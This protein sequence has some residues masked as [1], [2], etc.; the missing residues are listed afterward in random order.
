MY[1][2][3]ENQN[4]QI[5]NFQQRPTFSS[6]LPGIAGVDGIPMWVFYVNRGQGIASFGVQDKDH[7][8]MEFLPADKSY[9]LVQVQGFRTFIKILED[10]EMTFLEPFSS[11]HKSDVMETMEIS[12]NKL[13]L[14]YINQENGIK[15]TVEYFILPESPVAGLVR[16][17][18]FKNISNKERQFELLDGLP[19]VFPSGVPNAAYKELGNTIKS[20]FDVYNLENNIPFYKLRGSMEDTAEVKEVHQGN[21]F[22]SLVSYRGEEKLAEPIVDRDIIFGTDTTLQLPQN[23]ISQ[24]ID[25]LVAEEAYTTNKVS[26]GF[27]ATNVTLAANEELELYTVVGHASNLATVNSY[28]KEHITLPRLRAMQETATTI[29]DQITAPIKCETG[30]PLFDAYSRQS[31]LDNGLRGGFPFVFEKEDKQN[32]YYLYSRKHG[33]LERDYNF[34]SLSPTYYSQGNGN[35]RDINQNRR[36]DVFFEP[37][38]KDYNLKMFMNLIQLDGYNPLG[39]KGVRFSIDA[40]SFDFTPFVT[41]ESKEMVRNFFNS[42]YTPGELKHFLEDEAV[43]LSTSFDEFLTAVLSVSEHLFQAEFGEGYWMDHWTY[44]LDLVE[45]YLAIYPDKVNELYFNKDYQFFESPA[46][47]K[48]RADKYVVNNGKLRQYGAVYEDKQKEHEA[49]QNNGVMW[50]KD[51]HGQGDVYKTTLYSKLFLLGLVKAATLAPMGLGVEMESD[52]PGWN[53]SL[54]GLPGMIGAS[55]SELFEVK[56]LFDILLEVDGEEKV[57][58]P[59]EA[60]DFLT[61]VVN[62]IK[63]VEASSINDDQYWHE[64]ATLRENYRETI[65]QGISGEEVQY[66]VSE[67]KEISQIIKSRVESGIK[68][69]REFNGE[70]VPTYFYFEPKNSLENGVPAISEL[71]WTPKAVTPFLEGIVKS[72][73]LT[74][75]K[76]EAKKI[77]D[78]VRASDIYDS[79]LGMYKTSM[80]IQEES[81]ELG[82]ANA[83]TPGWLENESVFLHMEYKYLLATLKSGLA[84]EFY[85]DMKTALIPFLDPQIYGRSTLENSSF[86]ASSANPNP[87]LHGRGFVSRLS[88][89]TIEFMNMWFVMMTGGKPFKFENDELVCK[90]SP[91]LPSWMFTDNGELSCMFLGKCELTYVNAKKV[92]TYG[93]GAAKA[94]EYTLTYGNGETI[95]VDGDTVRGTQAE[96]IRHGKV[97]NMTVKLG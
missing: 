13:A 40:N 78:A 10:G 33:D 54:N 11:Q 69:A 47:V 26:C 88:G 94:I 62:A 16:H 5:E 63:K 46:R 32:L 84:A 79:K 30:Q 76:E 92:D 81:N 77:Y 18:T 55:T 12:E 42:S 50:V 22:M 49:A 35:Y 25:T 14:E 71:E 28:V 31:Y 19:S 74:E 9:Q 61:G 7:A 37:R 75:D 3:K 65:Y 24:S 53:D 60:A 56:R 27:T 45:S 21:F 44:N 38:V 17:V 41:K 2:L 48:K 72:L 64:V 73:K 23:F 93:D 80:S 52:K 6:F 51:K 67:L 85:D 86:I 36:C 90:L 89:S 96:D 4:F 58:L 1:S 68:R 82:R 57:A 39:V 43:T 15:M 66:T 8:I 87:K 91:I 95:V 59:V 97:T 83:F 29:T 34:F 70:L 20:W